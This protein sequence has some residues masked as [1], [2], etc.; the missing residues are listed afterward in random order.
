MTETKFRFGTMDELNQ[1]LETHIP[2][3]IWGT[4]DQGNPGWIDPPAGEGSE[5][6]PGPQGEV[7]PQGPTGPAGEAG[8]QGPKGDTGD[9][10]VQ[11]IQGVQGVQGDPGPTGSPGADGAQ[12]IQGI[13]GVQGEPGVSNVPGPQGPQGDQ[14]IQGIQGVQGDP[15]PAGAD[16]SDGVGVPAGG[17]D[18]QVLA[19]ASA[20]DYAT[21][22][23][24]PSAGGVPPLYIPLVVPIA[25]NL[26]WTNMATALGF[27]GAAARSLFPIDLTGYTQVKFTVVKLSTAGATASVIMLRYY[28]SFSTTVGNYLQLG[29]TELS[30]AINV[31][32]QVLTTGW[33]DLV[34]GAKTAIFLAVVGSGG[35]G[36]I[37]PVFGPIIAEFK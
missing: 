20:T 1:L 33:V 28:T 32:N 36:V 21:E 31:T 22:W 3:Q 23:V 34:A 25:A 5:G 26:A 13:Q 24:T 14:G 16:G 8:A 7:G 2:G 30:L 12:G 37:D 6:P 9:Q 15:G 18:G 19:K 35:D 29:A 17:T 10:G 27:F 11:G 4:N